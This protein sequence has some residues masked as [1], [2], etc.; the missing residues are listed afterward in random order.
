MLVGVF[1]ARVHLLSR[2][3]SS[4]RDNYLEMIVLSFTSRGQGPHESL[5]LSDSPPLP[6]FVTQADRHVTVH[7]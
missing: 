7:D 4:V 5:L 6:G 1:Q 2:Q 3:V